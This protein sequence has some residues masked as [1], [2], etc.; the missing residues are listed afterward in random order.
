M[1]GESPQ[2]DGSWKPHPRR[3][4]PR[5]PI[6]HVAPAVP[7]G[8]GGGCRTLYVRTQDSLKVETGGI[9]ICCDASLAPTLRRGEKLLEA[10]MGTWRMWCVWWG[11]FV[12]G[13][14]Q[15]VPRPQTRPPALN[16]LMGR[17]L[18]C[19]RKAGRQPVRTKSLSAREQNP[20][21]IITGA[22]A[23]MW[24]LGNPGSLDV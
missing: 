18:G 24:D 1:Q 11:Q 17:Q 3:V 21:R 10:H 19:P 5:R 16:G 13:W 15:N 20:S 14:A 22:V 23:L 4:K 7:S 12:R 8:D 6:Y 2:S 9:W